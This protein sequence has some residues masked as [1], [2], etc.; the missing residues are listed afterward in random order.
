MCG[1]GVHAHLDQRRGDQGRDQDVERRGR[2]AHA[3]DDA[4][5]CGEQH[6]TQQVALSDLHQ[7]ERHAESEAR[8]VDQADH[9]AGHGPDDDDIHRRPAGALRRFDDVAHADAATLVTED[10]AHRDDGHRRPQG[11]LLRRAVPVEQREH[12]HHEGQGEEPS[13]LE[14][15]AQRRDPVLGQRSDA[16]ARGLQV[17]LRECGDVVER[18]RHEGGENDIGIRDLQELGHQESRRPHHRWRDLPAGGGDRLERAGDLAREAGLA[19]QRNREDSGGR[20][21]GYRVAGD[22]AEHGRCH[23]RDLGRAAAGAAHERGGKLSEP[24][25]AAG[26]NQELA[27]EDVHHH[28]DAADVHGQPEQGDLVDPQVR[29]QLR[30]LHR[31]SLKGPRHEIAEQGVDNEQEQQHHQAPAGGAAQRLDGERNDDYADREGL[32]RTVEELLGQYRIADGE[33]GGAR[34]SENREHDVEPGHPGPRRAA[35]GRHGKED[36]RQGHGKNERQ[37][38]LGEQVQAE[39]QMQVDSERGRDHGDRGADVRHQPR[40]QG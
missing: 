30:E 34:E 31:A 21:V 27:H 13:F 32:R 19:H 5:D 35:P 3:D 7:Q 20:D 33:P 24:L 12:Q 8:N 6:Q 16:I 22:R 23:H 18:G 25:G 28:H 37:P 29:D 15:L 36:D 38:L 4:D 10:Q 11:G 39:L 1:Q 2:H 9:H 40:H 26:P 17:G 14:H